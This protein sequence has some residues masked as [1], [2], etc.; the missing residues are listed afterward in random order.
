VLTGFA[1]GCFHL[2]LILIA[3]TYDSDGARWFVAPSVV[4]TITAAGVFYAFVRDRSTGVWPVAFAHNAANTAFDLGA[5][6]TVATGSA[7][8]LAYVAGESGL[9]TMGAVV[10]VAGALLRRPGAWD[11]AAPELVGSAR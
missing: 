4:V 9:A 8:S 6:A 2:P 5:Q 3:T 10:L 7:A 1:H 11:T